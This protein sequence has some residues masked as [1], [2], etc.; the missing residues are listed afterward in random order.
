[1]AD[2]NGYLRGKM[3]CWG[4]DADWEGPLIQQPSVIVRISQ[5]D[6]EAKI[7]MLTDTA[8]THA[9]IEHFKQWASSL[10]KFRSV[11]ILEDKGLAEAYKHYQPRII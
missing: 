4:G 10:A 6:M 7:K 2:R 8:K 5:E 9:P 1:M 11:S 3:Q